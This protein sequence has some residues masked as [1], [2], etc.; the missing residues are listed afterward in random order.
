M[1]VDA[2]MTEQPITLCFKWGSNSDF[3]GPFYR[4]VGNAMVSTMVFNAYY[5]ILEFLMY[6]GMRLAF[7]ILDRGI[8]KCTCDKYSTTATSIQSYRN[9][10]NG[11]SYYIHYKYST[12][13]NTIFVTM[14]FGFGLPYLFAVAMI[15]FVILYFIEKTMLYYSYM[16]PPMY[17]ERLNGTVLGFMKYAPLFFLGF[18]YWM[19]SN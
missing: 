13:L 11:P 2:D 15:S 14:M 10:Y 3:N 9:V 19:A 6:W 1:L 18:G 8:C 4:D 5:P 17:D 12:I 16:Q 7:R